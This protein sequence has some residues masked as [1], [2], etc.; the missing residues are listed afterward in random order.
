MRLRNT[1]VLTRWSPDRALEDVSHLVLLHPIGRQSDH[2]A[3]ALGEQIVNLRVGETRVA[4]EI[5]PLHRGLVSGD[6]RAH[7]RALYI[8]ELVALEHNSG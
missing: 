1:G 2:V 4:S 7:G 5:A 3:V 6:T 8:A